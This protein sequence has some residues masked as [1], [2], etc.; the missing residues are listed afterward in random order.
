MDDLFLINARLFELCGGRSLDSCACLPSLSLSLFFIALARARVASSDFFITHD[1]WP[2]KLVFALVV[3]FDLSIDT[4]I[5]DT[6]FFLW[7]ENADGDS[8]PREGEKQQY[9]TLFAKM[10]LR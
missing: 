5:N 2:E 4:T 9:M 7:H 6:I 1:C 3:F 8:R 10:P